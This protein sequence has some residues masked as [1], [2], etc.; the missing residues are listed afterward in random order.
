MGDS[1]EVINLRILTWI[2]VTQARNNLEMKKRLKERKKKRNAGAVL[3][4]LTADVEVITP[5]ALCVSILCI[6]MMVSEASCAYIYYIFFPCAS[7][8]HIL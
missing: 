8:Y 1:T 5:T 2:M 6:F 3:I 4:N 7:D